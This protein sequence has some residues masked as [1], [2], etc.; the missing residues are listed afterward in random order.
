MKADR[1]ACRDQNFLPGAGIASRASALT[2]HRKLA[3]VGDDDRFSVLKRG[4]EEL[5]N[6]LQQLGRLCFRNAGL[7][8]NASGNI[9]LSH[10][11]LFPFELFPVLLQEIAE[12]FFHQVIESTLLTSRKH[13]GLD[14]K[15]G[16]DP[17][18]KLL[19]GNGGLVIFH[20][21]EP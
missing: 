19:P 20:E 15:S 9:G 4:F 1:S 11:V 10:P 18:S 3:K 21:A 2:A 7:L 5:Q 12:G 13:F 6:P 16:I 17:D 14:H 8:M